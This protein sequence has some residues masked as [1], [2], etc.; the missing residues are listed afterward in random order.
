MGAGCGDGLCGACNRRRGA[1]A[2]REWHASGR[3]P[4]H[5]RPAR[6]RG[7]HRQYPVL[8]GNFSRWPEHRLYRQRREQEPT[9]GTRPR[10]PGTAA[11]ERSRSGC[12]AILVARWTLGCLFYRRRLAAALEGPRRGRRRDLAVPGDCALWRDMGQERRDP[13]R[14]RICRPALPRAGIGGLAGAGHFPRQDAPSDRAPH[15]LVPSRRRP[16][17]V[18]RPA[19]RGPGCGRFRRLAAVEAGE[20]CNGC[21]LGSDLCRAGLSSLRARWQAG[22]PAFRSLAARSGRA[23]RSLSG[24]RLWPRR[25]GGKQPGSPRHHSTGAWQVS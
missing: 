22:R 13:F 24:T 3:E 15:A 14:S 23:S 18:C 17:S 10:K 6:W 1:V 7:D 25:H 12:A 11:S 19:A 4:S 8:P 21:S 2:G 5:C 20:A 16:L 9:L